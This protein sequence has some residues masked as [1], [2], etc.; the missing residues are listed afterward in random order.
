[1]VGNGRGEGG[2]GEGVEGEGG[3]GGGGWVGVGE[4]GEWSYS[5]I[6]LSLAQEFPQVQ[7]F[8]VQHDYLLSSVP[9]M[10]TRIRRRGQ[11]GTSLVT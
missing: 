5:G 11:N 3:W 6:W 2:G 1:M 7:D 4:V 10:Q 8:E 9:E